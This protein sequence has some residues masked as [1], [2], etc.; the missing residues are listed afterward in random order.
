MLSNI[1]HQKDLALSMSQ[2]IYDIW[3]ESYTYTYFEHLFS[4]EVIIICNWLQA[5]YRLSTGLNTLRPGQNGRHFTD[6]FE[7]HF[8]KCKS[9]YF[10]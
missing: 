8:F 9:L 5:K 1:Y 7:T 3:K 2:Y 6:I 10:D 4:Y